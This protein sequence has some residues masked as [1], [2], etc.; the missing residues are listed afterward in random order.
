MPKIT[1]VLPPKNE[2]GVKAALEKLLSAAKAVGVPL[3]LDGFVRSWL[4]DG[5]RV[6]VAY[7]GDTPTGFGIMAFGR[8]F[9]D[10]AFTA[11]VIVAAGKDRAA[12]LEFMLDMARVLGA[13]RLFYEAEDGDTIGGEPAAMKVVEVT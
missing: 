5:T 10:E 11:S 7:E 13:T 9:F 2:D 8:R 4:S 12:M 3:E 1:P 6:V